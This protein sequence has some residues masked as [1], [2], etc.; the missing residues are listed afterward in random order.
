MVQAEQD[1]ARRDLKI[2]CQELDQAQIRH[3]LGLATHTGCDWDSFCR[4]VCEISLMEESQSIG[5]EGKVVQ[6]DESKFGKRKYHR[7]HHVE[8]QWVFG[9][10]ES[11]SRKCFLIAV[12]KRDEQ[13]LLP[14]I[15]KWIKPGTTI[16]SD[17]WKAYCNLV[18]HGYMHRTVNHAKVKMPP[19]SVRKHHFSSYLAE[20]MWSYRNKNND[21]FEMFLQDVKKI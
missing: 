15:Q 19:F 7:G 21:L 3:E 16:I 11:D 8:G 20:F 18:K 4:E 10:I 5:G 13:T 2:Q 14:I 6:I 12:E 17:C 9:G 1:D